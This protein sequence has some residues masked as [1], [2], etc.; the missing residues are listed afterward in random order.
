VK[1]VVYT[2]HNGELRYLYTK[3]I[4]DVDFEGLLNKYGFIGLQVIELE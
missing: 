1:V 3:D 4:R 2:I